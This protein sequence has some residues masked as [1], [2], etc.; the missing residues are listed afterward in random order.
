M[1][2]YFILFLRNQ[3]SSVDIVIVFFLG[4]ALLPIVT[5]MSPCLTSL[6]IEIVSWCVSPETDVPLIV[7][8]S[9]PIWE[10]KIF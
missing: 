8:I 2:I 7:N 10:K 5:T 1:D 3:C 4:G 6:N 9:S